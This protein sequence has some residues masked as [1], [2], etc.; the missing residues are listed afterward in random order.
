MAA[1]RVVWS[2]R[3]GGLAGEGAHRQRLTSRVSPLHVDSFDF[4]DIR[5]KHSAG[6]ENGGLFAG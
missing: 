5:L 1:G 6:Q 2:R 4:A 3:V